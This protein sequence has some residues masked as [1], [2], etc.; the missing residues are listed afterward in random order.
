MPKW[1][2]NLVGRKEEPVIHRG[3]KDCTPAELAIKK[4][5]VAKHFRELYEPERI[6][7]NEEWNE[8]YQQI[9]REVA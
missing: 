6:K 3:L 8:K 9:I 1:L 4:E 2:D 5:I 7:A